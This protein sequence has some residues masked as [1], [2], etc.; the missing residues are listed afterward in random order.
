MSNR[1]P[2]TMDFQGFNVPSRVESDILALEVE[3][4]IPA[5]ING[6]WY[7]CIPD[8]QFPPMPGDDVFI[9]GDGM[10]GMYRFSN[11]RVDYKS[12]YVLTER[13]KNDRAAGRSL[14]GRY[15]NPF[16]DDPSVAGEPRGVA[17]TTPVYH[18]GRLL[19]LKEDSRA[20]QL[21][22]H[23]LE[24][25]GELDF[26]GRLK[27]LTMTA[28]PRMDPDTGE[29][30]FFGYEAGGLATRD[31]AYCVA[32]SN[33]ELSREEWF[34][35]PYV[36]MMHDFA[37]T[38]EHVIFPVFPTT[39]DLERL[40]AGG[41]HWVYEPDKES[42]IGI[43]PRDGSVRD[44]RW[45]RGP[46]RMAYHFMNAFTEGNKVH[47]DACLSEVNVF[48]FILEASGIKPTMEQM[49]GY[50]GRWTFDLSKPGEDFEETILGPGGDLPRI[51]ETD[52]M[53]DYEIGYYQTYHP[54]N[55]PPR[56]SGPVGAGFNTLMRLQMKT[57]AMK[58]FTMGPEVTFQEVQ[59]VPSGKPGHEGYLAMVIEHHDT[60]S[61]EMVI[62]EAEH[63]DRGPLATIKMPLRIRAGVHGNWVEEKYFL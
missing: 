9:S 24:T 50:L 13:L 2:D 62:L 6:T 56:I 51:R 28:H 33:G 39:C 41:S 49:A 4:E 11:G 15:R 25:L 14:Y 53:T 57:G 12:R 19:A 52:H 20:M 47:L 37:V 18:A 1:F 26:G 60:F 21:D 27:S 35:A 10:I 3:G 48:P 7:R 46:A 45:F 29:M 55:G 17:N 22:P 16:T 30:H 54:D 5:E 40:R 8:P 36:A 42:W 61:S 63:I 31:V 23:S 34:Q 32:D 59:P 43:M 38:K 44:I 58:S